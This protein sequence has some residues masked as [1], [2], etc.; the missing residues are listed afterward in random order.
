MFIHQSFKDSFNELRP[1]LKVK[2][3]LNNITTIPNEDIVTKLLT[4]F[5]PSSAF[6]NISHLKL[7][8]DDGHSE[9]IDVIFKLVKSIDDSYIWT[10]DRIYRRPGLVDMI[11]W[12]MPLESNEPELFQPWKIVRVCGAE[13]MRSV[14]FSW[15]WI[16][17]VAG[18]RSYIGKHFVI[19]WYT[20][21]PERNNVTNIYNWTL[22]KK[23]VYV[24]DANDNLFAIP[25]VVLVPTAI[26]D[27]KARYKKELLDKIIDNLQ[28]SEKYNTVRVT[29]KYQEA[30][31]DF[32]E[33][34]KLLHEKMAV[35][36]QDEAE[37]ILAIQENMVNILKQNVQISNV[38]YL[39]W[40]SLKVRTVPLWNN[41]Q[42]IGKY[43][44]ELWFPTWK[45]RCFNED[46]KSI[47]HK[48]H[49]HI[50]SDGSCC[51]SDWM[52]PMKLSYEQQDYITLVG[53]IISYLESLNPNSTYI[54]MADFQSHHGKKFAYMKT[55]TPTKSADTLEQPVVTAPPTEVI[56]LVEDTITF[57]DVLL[58]NQWDRV[59]LNTEGLSDEIFWSV[60]RVQLYWPIATMVHFDSWHAHTVS[61]QHLVKINEDETR[62]QVGQRVIVFDDA[63]WWHSRWTIGTIVECLLGDDTD[64]YRIN[65]NSTTFVHHIDN[66]YLVI[67]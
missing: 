65:A 40:Q 59:M 8:S 19:V 25:Q 32:M 11:N 6:T 3:W 51:L 62:L 31:R 33:A 42:P 10:T 57:D 29:E 63:D 64:S 21:N 18:L 23:L 43:R 7:I 67:E 54:S 52:N 34:S 38:E 46:I 49:P 53:S 44:I 55:K 4:I 5:W 9:Y 1:E 15:T 17:G 16:P 50:Q 47:A 39:E 60:G 2:L 20:P 66:I 48:Q 28:N 61:N 30:L 27:L 41:N 56:D 13:K 58:F 26:K 35:N 14:W 22:V 45:L 24:A 12:S 36:L 37:K